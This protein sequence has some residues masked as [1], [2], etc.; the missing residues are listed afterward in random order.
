MC[1]YQR[2]DESGNI[3]TLNNESKRKAYI[4]LIF[5]RELVLNKLGYFDC[6]RYGAD[7]EFFE[8]MQVIFGKQAVK[9]LPDIMYTA[10]Y[11]ANSLT[12]DSI[13]HSTGECNNYYTDMPALRRI[14]QNKFRKWH[15]E[16]KRFKT[17]AYINFPQAG[18]Y[19]YCMPN[20]LRVNELNNLERIEKI[21]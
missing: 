15:E 12:S 5:D 4:S 18:A 14:Y 16:I 6:V 11:R 9:I 2:I 10:S 20:E 1:N 7:S 13:K 19:N 3:I 17:S 8:R 21:V